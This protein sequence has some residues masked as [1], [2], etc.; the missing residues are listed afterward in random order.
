[1][2][3]QDTVRLLR[4][5]DAG[6]KMGIEALNDVMDR[7]EN[8]QLRRTLHSSEQEH[9]ALAQDIRPFL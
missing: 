4:E 8:E 5:C 3:E 7:V 9:R 1:M 2:I 6:A